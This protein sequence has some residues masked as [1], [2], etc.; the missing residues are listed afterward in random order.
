MVAQDAY[1]YIKENLNPYAALQIDGLVQA[2]ESISVQAE[3]GAPKEM[4]YLDGSIT[5]GFFFS[6]RAKSADRAKANK[7]LEGVVDHFKANPRIQLNNACFFSAEPISNSYPYERNG[8]GTWIY[9]AQF[10]ITYDERVTL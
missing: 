1:N 5:G 6:V 9:T 10:K 7:W 3:K 8:D 2:R 4:V